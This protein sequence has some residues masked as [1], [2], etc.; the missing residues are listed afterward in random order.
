MEYLDALARLGA[1]SAHPGGFT[2]TL[3]QFRQ[4]PLPPGSR[5]LEVGCGTGRTACYLAKQGHKVTALDLRPDMLQKA[6]YRADKEGVEVTFAQGDIA[7]LP[8]DSNSF[9]I[10]MAESVTIFG[11]IPLALAEY[12]RVL[13]PGG[14]LYD[15]EVVVMRELPDEEQRQLADFFGYSRLLT[16]DE[17]VSALHRAGFGQ[18]QIWNPSPF[19]EALGEDLIHH[20]DELQVV[21]RGA[22]LDPDIWQKT[23]RHDEL[24][25]NNREHL[26]H[27]V[28]IGRKGPDDRS[29]ESEAE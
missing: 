23:A 11:N 17:W 1:G 12:C 24:I 28:M 16:C 21:D 29:S 7:A 13:R 19:P 26:G 10:V 25:D 6:R 15:R 2:A 22:F 8:L 14:T 18:A 20:P 3:E 27:A 9:D 5:I 4:L